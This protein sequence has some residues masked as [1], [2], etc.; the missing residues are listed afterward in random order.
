MRSV[1]NRGV[2]CKWL[3]H[4][5]PCFSAPARA[6]IAQVARGQRL[7]GQAALALRNDD[8]HPLLVGP[9]LSLG[10]PLLLALTHHPL[11]LLAVGP[12]EARR[13]RRRSRYA[14]AR[15]KRHHRVR[16]ALDCTVGVAGLP[17]RPGVR[18][19]R[20][21]HLGFRSPGRR[22][23]GPRS[24]SGGLARSRLWPQRRRARLGDLD[25]RDTIRSEAHEP[26][27]GI[28]EEE[29]AA[30]SCAKSMGNG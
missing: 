28:H 14:T 15:C 19:A 20:G 6:L 27:A 13:V 25:R 23:C 21:Q 5:P 11:P 18:H 30:S 24:L 2:R 4:P 12:A 7:T 8:P 22:S 17:G 9:A 16:H 10:F 29:H 26:G 1:T 3:L